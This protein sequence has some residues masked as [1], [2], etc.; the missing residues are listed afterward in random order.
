MFSIMSCRGMCGF[1]LI[2]VSSEVVLQCELI[3]FCN[4][5]ENIDLILYRWPH[6]VGTVRVVVPT[7]CHTSALPHFLARGL[8]RASEPLC[9]ALL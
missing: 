1:P 5:W 2:L 3:S 4:K 9:A 6:I 7:D 8:H